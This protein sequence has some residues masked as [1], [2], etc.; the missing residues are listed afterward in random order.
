MSSGMCGVEP[1]DGTRRRGMSG[2][3]RSVAQP[4]VA[5]TT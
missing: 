3:R 2:N 4:L 5:L 1:S